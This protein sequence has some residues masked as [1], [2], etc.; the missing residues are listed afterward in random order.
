MDFRQ[1]VSEV[2]KLSPRSSRA[3]LSMEVGDAVRCTL[4]TF[5]RARGGYCCGNQGGT[6]DTDFVPCWG[7]VFLFFMETR[8]KKGETR[9]K[10][11]L[12]QIKKEAIEQIKASDMPE[13]LN[14]VRVRFL[15]KKG[16]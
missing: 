1:E 6:A 8:I 11:R 7:G 9:M 13:K 5:W 12:E 10:E 4:H 2:R 3:D 15:G 16:E 14:D